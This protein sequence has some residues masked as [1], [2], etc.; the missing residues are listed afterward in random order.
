MTVCRIGARVEALPTGNPTEYSS[1]SLKTRRR[2]PH[3]SACPS[4]LTLLLVISANRS[5][6][7]APHHKKLIAC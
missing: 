2:R 6:A 7:G 1:M 5:S 3:I 4:H